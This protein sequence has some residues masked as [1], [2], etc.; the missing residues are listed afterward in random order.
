MLYLFIYCVLTVQC[1]A[2]ESPKIQL[3]TVYRADLNK[4][5][6]IGEYFISEKLDGIRGFWNGKNLYTRGGNLIYAPVWFT[7]NWPNEYIDGELWSNRGEFEKISSCVRRHK[8]D[9][10]QKTSCW[11]KIHF[12]M[13]D[14]PKHLGTFSQRIKQMNNLVE[15]TNSPYLLAIKQEKISSIT[16][17]HQRL[18]NIVKIGGEGLMLH[19][20]EARYKEGRSKD[21]MKLKQHDDAEAIVIAHLEGKGKYRNKMGSLKVKMSSGLIFKIGSGFTDKQRQKPPPIGSTVT[22]KYIGKTARGVPKF[23]SFLRIRQRPPM[24]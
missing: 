9:K 13:F 16:L 8:P 14:L 4:P 5:V 18:S 7:Q 3:A 15:I 1:Q 21:L 24:Q 11:L 12:M 19:H 23:A 22:F 10:Q 6:N 20:Q 17:L 2:K